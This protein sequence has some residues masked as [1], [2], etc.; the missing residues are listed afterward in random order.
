MISIPALR[1]PALRDNAQRSGGW[2]AGMLR[3]SAF[4]TR[5]RIPALAA[6]AFSDWRHSG[7]RALVLFSVVAAF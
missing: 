2:H 3:V 5:L 1:V 6:S 4:V 7:A